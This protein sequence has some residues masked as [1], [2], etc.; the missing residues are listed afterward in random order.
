VEEARKRGI[1]RIIVTHPEMGPM[2]TDPTMEQLQHV[3]GM[4]AYVEITASELIGRN[5]D[6]AVSAI[7]TLGPAHCIVSSDSGLV[8]SHNHADALVLAARVL[9]EEGFSE[10]Q[11]N[12]MFK[13]NP[14]KALGLSPPPAG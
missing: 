4:G 12:A 2:F 7:R 11:L 3:A 14:A 10:E 6:V 5:R 8:G 1:D 9:R 13:E